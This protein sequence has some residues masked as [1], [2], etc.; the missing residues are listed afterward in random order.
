[1]RRGRKQPVGTKPDEAKGRGVRPHPGPV[2]NGG[3][4]PHLRV[5]SPHPPEQVTGK[6]LACLPRPRGTGSWPLSPQAAQGQKA[7]PSDHDS[8]PMSVAQLG[9]R[10]H[11]DQLLVG[12]EGTIPQVRAGGWLLTGGAVP[13][14]LGLQGV[15]VLGHRGGERPQDPRRSRSRG[16]GWVLCRE[17]LWPGRDGQGLC[18]HHPPRSPPRRRP[19]VWTGGRGSPPSQKEPETP[20]VPAGRAR[21]GAT[22]THTPPSPGGPR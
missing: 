20:P 19:L 15:G 8:W 3:W 9:G 2:R 11:T 10:G 16:R 1:M 6:A 4:N 12:G 21:R 7:R 17:G 22:P 14:E 13:G 5:G 18:V